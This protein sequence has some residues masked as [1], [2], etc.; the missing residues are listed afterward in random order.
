MSDNTVE[1]SRG[2]F[3]RNLK[4]EFKKII[5]PDRK[6]VIRQVVLILIVTII[7]GVLIKLLDTG[8]QALLSLIA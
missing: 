3:F 6:S 1:K 2:S 4:I 7:L 5:W 8:V